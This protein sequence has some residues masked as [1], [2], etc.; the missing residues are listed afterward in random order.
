MLSVDRI[1]V[2][3]AVY[4]A[5]STIEACIR[6]LLEMRRGFGDRLR[7]LTDPKR[8]LLRNGS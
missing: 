1:A 8:G 4:N 2:I 3:V 6:S 5:E 7:L